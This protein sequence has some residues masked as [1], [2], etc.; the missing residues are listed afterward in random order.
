MG[1][2]YSYG[3]AQVYPLSVCFD[4]FTPGMLAAWQTR[5]SRKYSHWPRCSRAVFRRY[6]K[7]MSRRRS[8]G[9]AVPRETVSPLGQRVSSARRRE[10]G[11]RPP[12]KSAGRITD[13]PRKQPGSRRLA[14]MA[15]VRQRGSQLRPRLYRYTFR[16]LMARARRSM[17]GHSGAR[18]MS[19]NSAGVGLTG[20]RS[21]PNTRR[22]EQVKHNETSPGFGPPSPVK[23]V[24]A[25]SGAA[26]YG[27]GT[28]GPRVVLIQFP[29]PCSTAARRRAV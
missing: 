26:Q 18:W 20:F 5:H 22:P 3:C 24:A 11:Y 10:S 8:R 7:N 12:R 23:F 16:A 17:V 2:V 28:Q 1:L 6:L 29:R 14:S 25:S 9:A 27:H 15:D 4:S 13:R 21:R 19:I